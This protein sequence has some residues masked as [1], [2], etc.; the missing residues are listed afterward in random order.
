MSHDGAMSLRVPGG[1]IAAIWR[2]PALS[3]V[4]ASYTTE[5]NRR[6]M[7]SRESSLL[8]SA[9]TSAFVRHAA[10]LWSIITAALHQS[11]H[12]ERDFMFCWLFK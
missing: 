4:R 10:I 2:A 9:V 1:Q 6:N 3:P 11:G 5:A 8:S 12:S 7:I